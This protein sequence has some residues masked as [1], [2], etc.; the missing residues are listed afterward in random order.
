LFAQGTAGGF[1]GSGSQWDAIG[2]VGYQF[3]DWCVATLGYRY[4][5]E[6]HESSDFTFNATAQGV[7]LG[8]GFKF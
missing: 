7:Q 3:T 5:S 1:S 6:D 8:V 4:L 2:G